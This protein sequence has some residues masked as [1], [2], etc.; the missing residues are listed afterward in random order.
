VTRPQPDSAAVRRLTA[1][2]A[3]Y[4]AQLRTTCVATMLEGG[5]A[6]NALPQMARA[7]VNCRILPGASVDEVE[8]TLNRL[9]NDKEGGISRPTQALPSPASAL[10]PEIMGPVERIATK[11][12][13]IPVVPVMETG[14][15]DGRY[16]RNAGYATYGASGVFID[17]N[18]VR[19]HG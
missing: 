12:W 7:T 11:M 14:A 10:S 2:S 6:P 4:N 16:L 1:N 5:H 13:N 17:V 9:A 3:F 18:D 8:Q 19:A 15:T